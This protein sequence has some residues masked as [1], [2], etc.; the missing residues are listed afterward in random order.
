MSHAYYNENDP[1]AAAWLRE[2]I[3]AGLIAPGDVDDRSITDVLPNDLEPYAQCHFFAGIGGWSYALRLAGVADSDPVWT[4]SCPCQP[5][6][7]AGKQLGEK[8]ERHLWPAWFRLIEKRLPS[9]IFGEQVA[10]KAGREWYYTGVRPDV[11]RVGYAAGCADLCAASVR[12]PHIRQRLWW[13]AVAG[14]QPAGRLL[15]RPTEGDSED[16]ER[17][18]SELGGSGSARGVAVANGR[19]ASEEREQ[20]SGEQRQQPEDSGTMRLGDAASERLSEQRSFAGTSRE[21]SFAS[22]REAVERTG[23]PSSGMEHA[24]VEGLQGQSLGLLGSSGEGHWSR[25]DILNCLDGKARR[26]E[27]GTFP[28][29]HGIPG[30]V[31]LLRGYGNAIVPQVAAEFIKAAFEAINTPAP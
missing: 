27:S 10:S 9:I 8:D 26:I 30:R 19:H 4:G 23:S 13:M 15:S 5:F 20:R 12:A 16:C 28:L 6:S 18:S 31:G 3:K 29:A 24:N 22:T 17:A 25:F 2:L 7:Q 11:E 14:S 1:K 21:E